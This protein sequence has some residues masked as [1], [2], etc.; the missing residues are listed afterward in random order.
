MS[1]L[2]LEGLPKG[3]YPT[4]DDLASLFI[5]DV[6]LLDVRAPIEFKQ[7]AFPNAINIPLMDDAQREAVGTEYKEQGQDAAILLGAQ[8]ITAEERAERQRQ[9]AEFFIDHDSGKTGNPGEAETTLKRSDDDPK[10]EMKSSQ[11]W[12]GVLYCFR[13]G[14]RSQISQQWVFD[15]TN[16]QQPRVNGGY[17]AMRRFLIDSI[18]RLSQEMSIVVLGGRTGSGK[19]RLL[20]Q[21][22]NSIDLE[23]LANHRGSAFGPTATPQPTQ[24]NFENALAIEL[25]KKE[26][27]GHNVLVI[28]D[29]ARNV[30]SMGVP[31]SLYEAMQK[32][33]LVMLEVSEKDRNKVSIDEYILNT[34]QSFDEIYGEEQG[35]IELSKHLLS[36]LEKIKKRLGGVRYEEA[37]KLMLA[38]IKQRKQTGSVKGFIPIVSSLLVDYYDPMYDYQSQNKHERI[39]FKGGYTEILEYLSSDE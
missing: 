2:K 35:E 8:L 27:A 6:P 30:G 12:G 9:W 7:G 17:K 1:D 18:E 19:T 21:L 15:Q 23:G 33:P 4:V 24:I 16:T 20:K 14:L 28:E 37:K 22:D 25:L 32:S 39:V 11:K 38:A 13:G 34:Q 36:S 31:T 26:A 5:N 10:G 29:E 3:D